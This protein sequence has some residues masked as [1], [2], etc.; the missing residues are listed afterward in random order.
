M[1]LVLARNPVVQLVAALFLLMLCASLSGP[2]RV[3]ANTDPSCIAKEQAAGPC[4]DMPY[5]PTYY[6]KN[7]K[8]STT[9][10]GTTKPGY[11]GAPCKESDGTAFN[12]GGKCVPGAKCLCETCKADG[13]KGDKGGMPPML[14]MLPMPMSMPSMDMPMMPG[15]QPCVA[16][17]RTVTTSSTTDT[18]PLIRTVTINGVTTVSTTTRSTTT[19]VT[20]TVPSTD[21]LCRDNPYAAGCEASGTSGLLNS[22]NGGTGSALQNT[23][24]GALDRLGSVANTVGSSIINTA[25]NA[26]ENLTGIDIDTSFTRETG[27]TSVVVTPVATTDTAYAQA[28]YGTPTAMPM[29]NAPQY[30]YDSDTTQYGA[31]GGDTPPPTGVA[32]WTNALSSVLS[33]LG[34]A[35]STLFGIL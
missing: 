27:P 7:G 9:G 19:P 29:T 10:S 24:L 35:L 21:C 14:P 15:T 4:K 1:N 20:M 30:A 2:S 12:V 23:A 32:A 31:F 5:G 16:T 26:I 6:V 8:C 17:S 11:I 34:Q 3:E 28:A 18:T 25:A 22:F 13:D 33:Q